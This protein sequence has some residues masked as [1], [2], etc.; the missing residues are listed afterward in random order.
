M[1]RVV[2]C[3]IFSA[4]LLLHRAG[5]QAPERTAKVK[6]LDE[7]A[8]YYA[9]QGRFMGTVLVAE[10]DDVCLAKAMAMRIWSG[11]SLS[12]RMPSFTLLP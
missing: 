7:I 2:K 1:T 8:S 11:P 5:A 3:L 9:Q 6:R 12:N 10:G 4:A